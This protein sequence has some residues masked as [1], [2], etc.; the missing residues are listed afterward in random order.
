MRDMVKG[1]DQDMLVTFK[2]LGLEASF[3]TTSM[4]PLEYS[5]VWIER[6]VEDARLEL[7]PITTRGLSAGDPH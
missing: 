7:N 5:M 1:F 2:P 4:T 6:F 3:I